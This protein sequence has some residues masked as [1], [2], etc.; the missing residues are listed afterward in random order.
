VSLV[1]ERSR[2]TDLLFRIGGEEFVL[3]LAE[4]SEDAAI[5]VA[6]DLRERVAT[7]LLIRERPV[8]ISIGVAELRAGES[9]DDWLK[10]ADN[11]LY[12]AKAA[13]RN[14]VERHAPLVATR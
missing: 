2:R 5:G 12:R 3:L 7:A 8:T 10:R 6:E 4:T 11:A 14:R 9:L 1:Q 13:G